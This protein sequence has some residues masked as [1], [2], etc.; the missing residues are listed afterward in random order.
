MPDRFMDLEAKLAAV[1][2]QVEL[3]FRALLR[4]VERHRLFSHARRVIDHLQ[5]VNELVTT[6]LILASKRVR[7]GALLDLVILEAVGGHARAA[8]GACLIDA[9]AERR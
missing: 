2:N 7:I 1:Q 5:I 9:A 4:R 3:A 8:Y 6:E